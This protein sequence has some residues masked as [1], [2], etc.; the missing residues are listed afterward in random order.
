M[1]NGT[2]LR[3]GWQRRGDKNIRHAITLFEQATELDPLFSR[4]W[5]SLTQNDSLGGAYAVLGG[6]ADV[7]GFDRNKFVWYFWSSNM[8]PFRQDPRFAALVTEMKMLDYWRE[9]GW[10]DDCQPAGD[11]VICK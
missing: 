4:A 9:Y 5:S 6:L 7:D 8:A 11:S 3:A 10:P 2:I 1:T